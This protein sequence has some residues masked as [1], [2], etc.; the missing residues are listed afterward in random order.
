MISLLGVSVLLITA[1]VGVYWLVTYFMRH[2]RSNPIIDK[3]VQE[4]SA[5]FISSSAQLHAVLGMTGEAATDLRPQGF[6]TIDGLRYDAQTQ[7]GE[8]VYKGTYIEV[9]GLSG[10]FL[11]VR[12][13]TPPSL[14]AGV[15][16][17]QRV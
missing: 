12:R 2:D 7:S 16:Q 1:G 3:D 4:K 15:Q 6:V 8:Y 17:E 5:G 9:V 13:A 10:Q 14:P 11:V